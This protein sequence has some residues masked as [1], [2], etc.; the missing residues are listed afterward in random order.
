MFSIFFKRTQV[1]SLQTLKE[2]CVFMFPII[3][4]ACLLGLPVRYDG[5]VV[6]YENTHLN[7]WRREGRLLAVCP[8]I[9]AGL[10][11]PRPKAEIINGDG[12]AVLTGKARIKDM[13]GNDV[14]HDFIKGAM[15][16][17]RCAISYSVSTAILKE[18]SPSCACHSV[19][20]GSFSVVLQPGQGVTAALL[21]MNGVAVCS[22]DE[23]ALLSQANIKNL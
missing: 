11:T 18:N 12:K 14:T 8:E 21:Q 1:N 10:P 4:S 5:R 23:L 17:L 20:D 6:H 13:N 3:V 9:L 19:Y 15:A 22:E 7:R 2:R 16:V